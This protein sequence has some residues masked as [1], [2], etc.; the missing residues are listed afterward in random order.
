MP[1]AILSVLYELNFTINN[2]LCVALLTHFRDRETEARGSLIFLKL[3]CKQMTALGFRSR[4]FDSRAH[5]LDHHP[6]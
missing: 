6:L 4:H 1:D 5:N 2:V 3:H